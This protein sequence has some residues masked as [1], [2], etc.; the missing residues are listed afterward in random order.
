MDDRCEWNMDE[1][2][3]VKF[4]FKGTGSQDKGPLNWTILSVHAHNWFFTFWAALWK[5]K[6][7]I[8][9]LLA[10]LKTLFKST[11][12]SDSR[13]GICVPAFI[14]CYSGP[15]SPTYS[16]YQRWLSEQFSGLQA[17]FGT[18]FNMKDGFMKAGKSFL[19]V[20]RRIFR[21]SK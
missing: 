18:I 13:I 17:V 21:N 14:C 6:M 16:R 2:R 8:N 7:I 10:Y 15:F 3:I 20:T 19:S 4:C 12:W 9:Y 5:R 11:E 1:S